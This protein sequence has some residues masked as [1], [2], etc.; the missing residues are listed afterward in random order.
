[1]AERFPAPAVQQSVAVDRALSDD[2]DQRLSDGELTIVPT[3][4]PHDAQTLYR[5][6]SVPG[7]G[8]MLSVVL[9]SEMHDLTRFPR[10]QEFVS[11]GRLVTWAKDSAGTR[12][13]PSGAKSG[14]TSL[15]WAFS[16]AAVLCLRNHPAAPQ[17]LARLAPPH[18]TGTA[19]TVFAHHVARAV[20]A[21]LKR[22]TASNRPQFRNGS[23][24]GAGEPTA[25]L[26]AHGRSLTGGAL[27]LSVRQGTRGST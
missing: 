4:K 12:D 24:S 2:D 20:Y 19:L 16:A 11:Y 7:I 6:P 1:V 10:V 5:R 18:G 21:M 23:W 13:G 27:M 25:S 15:K 22:D 8:T 26:D 14:T 9:R 17:Y 3:A